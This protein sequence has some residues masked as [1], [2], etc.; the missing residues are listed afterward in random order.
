MSETNKQERAQILASRLNLLFIFMGD[1]R[2]F[3]DLLEEVSQSSANRA[4]LAV[5]MAPIF[6]AMGEDYEQVE[7][8]N[9]LYAKRAGAILNLIDI[10]DETEAMRQEFITSQAAKQ[11][12][13]EQL[14][15]M[16]GGM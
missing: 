16:L 14:R 2:E 1:I 12:G 3:K 4:S 8:E 15:E 5:T 7:M 10:L 6:G 11:K 13:R 9:K